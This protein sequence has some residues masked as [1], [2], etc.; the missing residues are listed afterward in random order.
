MKRSRLSLVRL[1]VAQVA[2]LL[3]V[4]ARQARALIVSGPLDGIRVGR[5]L[6]VEAGALQEFQ[7]GRA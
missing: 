5:R 6:F 1:T 4:S 3:Q 7:Q 2:A